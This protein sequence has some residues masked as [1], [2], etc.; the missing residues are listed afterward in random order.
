MNRALETERLSLRP[1]RLEDAGGWHDIWGDSEVIWWGAS[2]SFEKSRAG[3]E[4]LIAKEATW[5]DGIGWLA[6][7]LK[8]T[9]EI[10]GDVLLQPA[11]FAPGIEIGWHFRRRAWGNGYATEAAQAVLN[12]CFE[13]GTCDRIYA[14]VA[15]ENA[16]SLRIV[17]KLGM[18]AEKDM[19]YTGLPHRLFAVEPDDE[20]H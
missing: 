1:F 4:R 17:E 8:G 2:E 9:D 10:I 19:E 7:R 3:L 11:P 5:P 14:I 13:E 20:R 16:R 12:R 18:P 15:L 6:V